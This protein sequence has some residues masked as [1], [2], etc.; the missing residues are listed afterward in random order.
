MT[1]TRKMARPA[2]RWLKVIVAGLAAAPGTASAQALDLFYERT[3]LRAADERC[4]LLSPEIAT[5]LAAGAAQARGAALRAGVGERSTRAVERRALDRASRLP[6]ASPDL[7]READRVEKAYQAYSR[8]QRMTYPGEAADWRADR[9]YAKAPRWR[10]AQDARMGADRVTF[11]LAGRD[12][13]VL[14]AL[15]RFADGAAPY[16]ARL[17]LRD[18]GRTLGPYL[19][20][21]S[22]PLAARM[23]PA[24][25][26]RAFLA[27]ARDRADPALLAKDAKGGWTLRF[28]AAAADALAGLDPREAVAIEFLFAHDKVRTAHVEV[29]DFAAGRAFVRLAAR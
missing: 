6:C 17:V 3:V 23:P 19:P 24:R 5:A 26:L 21:A 10:L 16:G 9:A 1:E 18:T 25:S 29:G 12:T 2:S 7:A 28:P 4:E 11:G 27:D 8:I 13:P 14:V 22:A 15:A 20:G